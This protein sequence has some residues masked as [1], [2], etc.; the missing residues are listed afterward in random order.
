MIVHILTLEQ[1]FFTKEKFRPKTQPTQFCLKHK[2][3][4]IFSKSMIFT[5]LFVIS[6]ADFI[7]A[8]I[9]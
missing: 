1:V 7:S 4:L 9:F 3:T 6:N 8:E 2:N 5:S